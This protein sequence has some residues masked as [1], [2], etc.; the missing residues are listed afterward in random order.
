[1]K[2]NEFYVM[3]PVKMFSYNDESF[4]IE[5][6]DA[7]LLYFV[8]GKLSTFQDRTKVLCNVQMLG[9][10]VTL[11]NRKSRSTQRIIDALKTLELQ[12]YV[13]IK[14]E[15]EKL[16]DSPLLE[17]TLLEDF[18]ESVSGNTK[19]SGFIKVTEDLFN[20]A[21]N[22]SKLFKV[23][24]YV[25]WRFNIDYAISFREWENVLAMSERTVKRLIQGYEKE[26]KLKVI[27]GQHYRDEKG[28]VRQYMNKYLVPVVKEKKEKQS[29]QPVQRI[30]AETV[31][32][33]K[34]IQEEE[35]EVQP[36]P[37]NV[38][39]IEDDNGELKFY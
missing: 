25:V 17:I 24:I 29:P 23:L 11:D 4:F 9:A 5:N 36:V 3:F 32:K 31:T 33:F 8:L 7:F 34:E 12:G 27:H 15:G 39:V 35:I 6:S 28:K 18:S 2:T 13:Q 1:M 10:M 37:D 26:G 21:D 19:Y 30:E 16:Q 20:I 38:G 22:D 14:H